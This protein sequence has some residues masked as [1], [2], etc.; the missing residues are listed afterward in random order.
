[1]SVALYGSETLT[2]GKKNEVKVV[3]AY[4]ISSWREMLKIK[5]TVRTKNDEIL[6][7]AKEER[8][9]LKI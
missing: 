6:Q 5:W 3:N 9:I 7:R 1:M 8:L 2:L 4:E